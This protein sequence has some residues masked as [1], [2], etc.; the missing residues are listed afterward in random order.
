[1][2]NLDVSL[3]LKLINLLSGPAK[4]AARDLQSL[5]TTA[6]SLGKGSGA[7][8]SGAAAL[9]KDVRKLDESAK[10]AITSMR[11]MATATFQTP[12]NGLNNLKATYDK[13]NLSAAAFQRSATAGMGNVVQ[14]QTKLRDEV[15][16]TTTEMEAL[17][18]R[19]QTLAGGAYVGRQIK[20]LADKLR[21][22][23]EGAMDQ[24]EEFE[25]KIFSIANAAGTL[26]NRKQLA[27]S[28]LEA[29]KASNLPWEDIA[30]GERKMAELGGGEFQGELA[31]KGRRKDLARLA[32]V[33]EASPEDIYQ[34]YFEHRKLGLDPDKTVQALYRDYAVGKKGAYELKNL[35]AGLPQLQQAGATFGQTPEQAATSI[36]TLL[37]MFRE[38]SGKTEAADTWMKHILSKLDDPKY[39]ERFRKELDVDVD[40]ERRAAK[41]AG[42]DPLLA[43]LDKLAGALTKQVDAAGEGAGKPNKET[44]EIEGVDPSKMGEVARDYYFRMGLNAYAR[45]R[46]EYGKYL[47]GTDAAYPEAVETWGQQR[48][49]TR[50][51]KEAKEIAQAEAAIRAGDTQMAAQRRMNELKRGAANV[52][53]NVSQ[54]MPGVTSFGLGAW[55]LGTSVLGAGGTIYQYGSSGLAALGGWELA[56]MKYPWL[57][58]AASNVGGAFKGAAEAPK[59]VSTELSA[60]MGE[61]AAQSPKVA[62]FMQRFA[63]VMRFLGPLA[64]AFGSYEAGKGGLVNLKELTEGK[65]GRK[66]TPAEIADE[67]AKLDAIA[68]Q[69][70]DA[71]ANYN[72][73]PNLSEAEAKGMGWGARVKDVAKVDLQPQGAQAMQSYA[74]GLESQGGQA[75]AK[76]STI[77]EQLKAMFN[78]TFTPT[79]APRVTAPSAAP[80]ASPAPGKQSRLRGSAVNIQHAHFHGVHDAGA[81]H[82]ELAGLSRAARGR[83]DDALH[84]VDTGGYA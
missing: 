57:G 60:A 72:P 36:P 65:R 10:K 17:Q 80:A 68:K 31:E 6:E 53:S 3:T 49:T 25:A 40:A 26:G 24:A 21:K 28:V 29:A 30:K 14:Q 69:R 7:S 74:K 47:E 20:E 77:V 67:T 15:K 54:N 46:G 41:A 56:K 11:G 34:L 70:R 78:T 61:A 43:V 45:K 64:A 38:S 62:I 83:R 63:A 39:K 81:M 55:N 48:A 5:K 66:L 84:D 32:K 73:M 12:I 13:L 52:G 79:I 76:A 9:D 16:K 50:G 27:Q 35:A 8:G 19:I 23:L 37:Q 59:I 33:S 1:M 22:P 75:V 58:G 42:K 4:D 2:S 82:R 71:A 44:G 51:T 18:Q